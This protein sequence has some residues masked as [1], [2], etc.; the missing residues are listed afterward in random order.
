MSQDTWPHDA[1]GDLA[2][3]ALAEEL[4]QHLGVAIRVDRMFRHRSAVA[5][6]LQGS[7]LPASL[8]EIPGLELSAAYV[9]ASEGLEVS[10][11][12]YDVFP[13]QGGWAI[14]VGDV[15]GKDMTILVAK[16]KQATPD[17]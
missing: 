8:P 5:E 13:V 16:V 2:D 6:A 15:C 11:D 1:G 12:F 14:T 4:G 7:L 17:V 9:P 10:G 3:L